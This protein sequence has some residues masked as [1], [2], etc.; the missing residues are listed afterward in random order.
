MWYTSLLQFYDR[1]L[2]VFVSSWYSQFTGSN[3][4]M[5]ELRFS[6][7]Y[8]TATLVNRFLETDYVTVITDQLVPQVIAILSVNHLWQL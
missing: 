2:D 6:F 7:K 3:E 1:I 8:A 4:F 5:N